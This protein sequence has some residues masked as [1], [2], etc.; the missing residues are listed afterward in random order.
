MSWAMCPT[1]CP[2]R[3]SR[4]TLTVPSA[5]RPTF[6]RPTSARSSFEIDSATFLGEGANRLL[7]FTKALPPGG[8]ALACSCRSP[9][10][11][12]VCTVR[13]HRLT[14][15]PRAYHKPGDGRTFAPHA[16]PRASRCPASSIAIDGLTRR[17]AFHGGC[18]TSAGRL[19]VYSGL[20]PDTVTALPSVSC[21][22][23]KLRHARLISLR[24][25]FPVD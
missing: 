8:A 18:F 13:R 22:R 21:L 24:P 7:A 20:G 5:R 25:S 12:H 6:M 3:R 4:R 23:S 2:S 16:L 14:P 9:T 11:V 1:R 10:G 17:N 15:R 19:R